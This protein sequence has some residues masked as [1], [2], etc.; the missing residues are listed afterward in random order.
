MLAEKMEEYRPPRTLCAQ[1][2]WHGPEDRDEALRWCRPKAEIQRRPSPM[3]A[4]DC[5]RFQH[6]AEDA[7]SEAPPAQQKSRDSWTRAGSGQSR[8]ETS[9]AHEATDLDRRH[10]A[11]RSATIPVADDTIRT[12]AGEPQGMPPEHEGREPAAPEEMAVPRG[13]HEEP[14]GRGARRSA[15]EPEPQPEFRREEGGVPFLLDFKL[16]LEDLQFGRNYSGG[17]R[18]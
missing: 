7:E 1:H 3:P 13:R 11:E 9:S 18:R 17:D 14:E 4:Q 5:E 16:N 12:R 6:G 15:A 8:P 2:C 10:G